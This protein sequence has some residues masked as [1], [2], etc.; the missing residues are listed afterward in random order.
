MKTLWK[1]IN[2]DTYAVIINQVLAG[3]VRTN[4]SWK[5]VIDPFFSLIPE[6]LQDISI[7]YDGY[8]EAGRAL[9]GMWANK[10]DYDLAFSD[11]QND[12]SEYVQ[13]DED[14]EYYS[15][16]DYSDDI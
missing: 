16:L 15:H 4:N 5:W 12:W 13:S 8:V 11:F 9:A 6:D 10:K 2:D 14:E 7:E 1:K 3:R